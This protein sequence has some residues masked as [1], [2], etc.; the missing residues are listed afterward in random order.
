MPIVRIDF[1]SQKLSDADVQGLSKATQQIVSEVT[2]IEDVFV[3]ANSSKISYKIAPVEVFVEMSAQMITDADELM[4]RIKERVIEW[5]KQNN[6]GQPINLT[7][8][9]MHWKIEVGL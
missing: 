6:F 8:I 3:Y 5:K 9:P 7:L 2:G 4:G 1:D